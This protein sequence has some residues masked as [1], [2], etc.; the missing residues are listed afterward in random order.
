MRLKSCRVKNGSP[1]ARSWDEMNYDVLLEV[2]KRLPWRE[3]LFRVWKVSK[4]WLSAVLDSLSP[5]GVINLKV[6]DTPELQKM[7]NTYCVFLKRRLD[8][9][10][11]DSCSAFFHGKTFLQEH[12]YQYIAQRTPSMQQLMIPR[13]VGTTFAFILP[14]MRYWKKLKK[15]QCPSI[16]ISLCR[17]NFT[18]VET[19][20]LFGP[21]DDDVAA[22]IR[23][24]CPR[25]KRLRLDYC[26]LS[27][28][29]LSTILDGHKDL[30]LLDT[31]HSYLVPDC[32]EV[33]NT[34]WSR[35]IEWNEEEIRHKA[36]GVKVHLKCTRELCSV[37]AVPVR[38]CF[39]DIKSWRRIF[40]TYL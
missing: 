17:R 34:W 28:N 25:L 37:C 11:A 21:V 39:P 33:L 14:A 23:D 10:P 4:T 31:R 27:V 12:K 3:R 7:G 15:V 24:R 9:M 32:R 6:L 30:K 18:E 8:N 38:S 19:L 29:A 16:L 35:S 22:V 40:P 1:T 2:M 36:A 5:P 13:A 26:A 20:R